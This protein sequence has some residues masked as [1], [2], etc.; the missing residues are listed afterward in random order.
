MWRPG[1][2]ARCSRSYAYPAVTVA[3]LIKEG[4]K[5]YAKNI[6]YA[7][8]IIL[9]QLLGA[10]GGCLLTLLG[11]TYSTYPYELWPGI[12]IICPPNIKNT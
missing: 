5:N 11:L 1:S 9:S 8:Q 12:A 2:S 7:I 4:K 3:V 10:L 6:G